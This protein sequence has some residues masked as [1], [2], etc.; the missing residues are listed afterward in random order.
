MA[1]WRTADE[2]YDRLWPCV[3]TLEDAWKWSEE[4]GDP[5]HCARTSVMFCEMLRLNAV[6][7]RV[8]IK[9]TMLIQDF[10]G[11]LVSM[12]PYQ[13]TDSEIVADIVMRDRNSGSVTE[14]EVREDV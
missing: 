11:D 6:D 13:A 8:P 10:I 1:I 14:V 2:G 9:L 5:A 7:P 12:R 4:V 3:V